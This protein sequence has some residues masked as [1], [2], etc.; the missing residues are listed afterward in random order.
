MQIEVKTILGPYDPKPGREKEPKDSSINAGE[1]LERQKNLIQS[2][3]GKSIKGKKWNY[4]SACAYETDKRIPEQ[5]E[6]DKCQC[7][8]YVV[9]T[10][11]IP[12]LIKTIEDKFPLINDEDKIDED[13]ICFAK[14]LLFCLPCQK[15][16]VRSNEMDAVKKA[17]EEAGSVDN[18]ILWMPTRGQK[19][20][21][22]ED[23]LGNIYFNYWIIVKIG[24]KLIMGTHRSA[25]R[26]IS[27]TANDRN[28]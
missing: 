20:A 11:Q 19:S 18:I 23:F 13:F 24:A 3:F 22:S 28:V 8:D 16:T 27:T 7:D 15:L 6:Q 14:Y 2:L 17:V 9:K 5:H 10:T 12:E 1:Q 21:M 25:Y 4:V 26:V